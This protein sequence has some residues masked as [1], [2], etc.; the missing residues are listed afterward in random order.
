MHLFFLQYP[1]ILKI[2]DVSL[3]VGL[4]VS[5]YPGC[6]T[7]FYWRWGHVSIA[8]QDRWHNT[9]CTCMFVLSC[10]I[11][12]PEKEYALKIYLCLAMISGVMHQPVTRLFQGLTE[13]RSDILFFFFF[14]SMDKILERYERYSY[15]EKALISAESESEVRSHVVKFEM[16]LTFV[17]CGKT[18]PIMLH[19]YLRLYM[20]TITRIYMSISYIYGNFLVCFIISLIRTA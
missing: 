13:K 17:S 7:K 20:S 4:H 11:A 14:S 16:H 8:M 5:M 2:L 10:M 6:F 18:P 9:V 15:A 19:C 3:L 1:F 12:F